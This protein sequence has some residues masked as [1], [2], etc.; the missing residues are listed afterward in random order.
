MEAELFGPLKRAHIT[1][2]VV[3]EGSWAGSARGLRIRFD[4]LSLGGTRRV[5]WHVRGSGWDRKGVTGTVYEAMDAIALMWA[6]HAAARPA[7]PRQLSLF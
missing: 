5:A 4:L 6:K 2:A 7:S 3:E 1:Q